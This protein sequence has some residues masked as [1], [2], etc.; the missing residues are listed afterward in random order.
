MYVFLPGIAPCL[1]QK[2][3]KGS[4]NCAPGPQLTVTAAPAEYFLTLG[5]QIEISRGTYQLFRRRALDTQK[6]RSRDG[7]PHDVFGNRAVARQFLA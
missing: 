5:F 7:C 1:M 6:P 3:I 4:P 2:K